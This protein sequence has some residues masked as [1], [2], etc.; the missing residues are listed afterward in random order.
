M[1]KSDATSELM[2]GKRI[3]IIRQMFGYGSQ[4]A[5]CDEFSISASRYNN[6][7][8]GVRRPAIDEGIKIC[9]KFN[10]SLDFLY[11]GELKSV[12][13]DLGKALKEALDVI[14]TPER[15]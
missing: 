12:D 1:A 11:R 2:V 14:Q 3:E 9:E 7:I 4:K 10:L 13:Y 5:F 15:Q 8:K 6:W